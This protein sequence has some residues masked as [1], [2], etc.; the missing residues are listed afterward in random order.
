M[1][2]A[3]KPP[4]GGVEGLHAANGDHVQ[5]G[6]RPGRD[7]NRRFGCEGGL[8][9]TVDDQEDPARKEALHAGVS[10][11]SL[12]FYLELLPKLGLCVSQKNIMPPWGRPPATPIRCHSRASFSS[13]RD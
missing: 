10:A 11:R 1:P 12:W 7:L 4:R 9:G 3:P 5:L 8:F 6:A 13:S 2:P